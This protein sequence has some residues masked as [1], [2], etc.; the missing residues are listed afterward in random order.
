MR[1]RDIV[2]KEVARQA[3]FGMEP[4]WEDFAVAGVVAGTERTVEWIREHRQDP[5]LYCEVTYTIYQDDMKR[6]LHEWG[7]DN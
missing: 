3:E 7:I 2:E 4:S 1:I 6:K 5:P